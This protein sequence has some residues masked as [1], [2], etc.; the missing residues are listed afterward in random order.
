MRRSGVNRAI[1]DPKVYGSDGLDGTVPG[2][3]KGPD[4]GAEVSL[5]VVRC[6]WVSPAVKRTRALRGVGAVG[7]M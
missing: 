1:W 7:P 4:S 6:R 2:R 3:P 5:G